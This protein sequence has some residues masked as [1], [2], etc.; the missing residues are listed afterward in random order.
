MPETTLASLPAATHAAAVGSFDAATQAAINA[1][2]TAQN[3]N[4]TSL[5]ASIARL[6]FSTA[7]PGSE[8]NGALMTTVSTWV[9]VTAVG[10]CAAKLLCAYSGASGDY[11]TLRMRARSDAAGVAGGDGQVNGVVC[12]NFSASAG[13]NNH[14]SLFAVQG[15]AQ[16]GAFTT[17]NA[18]HI[19]CGVY[20]CID[21]IS[22]S[23]GRRWS[24][25]TDEHS[26]VK[27]S[28]GHYLHR[29][30]HNGTV[31]IDGLWTV[32]GGGRLPLLLNV[33]DATPGFVGTSGV[34]ASDFAARIAI[35]VNGVPMWLNAYSTSNA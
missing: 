23:S 3:A 22:A 35:S 2:V 16:P 21:G 12:G 28:G 31:A 32:Y 33:E 18:A 29:L 17:N 14:A 15:Y 25:W 20:S 1:I 27:A 13:I 8:T 26:T 5:R 19:A 24:L 4:N 10:G 34:A 7:A 11:A 6:D 30:S 9:P